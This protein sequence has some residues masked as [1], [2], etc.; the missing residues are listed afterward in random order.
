MNKQYPFKATEG[1]WLALDGTEIG[2]YTCETYT[3]TNS[4]CLNGNFS[5]TSAFSNWFSHF[6]EPNELSNKNNAK[7]D[8]TG[9][10]RDADK[11]EV[12]GNVAIC[13]KRFILSN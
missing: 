10:W 12:D 6:D 9:Y 11:T 4:R 2:K 7:M 5:S 1:T 13:T 8:R 3:F